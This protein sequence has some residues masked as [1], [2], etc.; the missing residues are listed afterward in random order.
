MS[1]RACA[2]VCLCEWVSVRKFMCA[3][4][5]VSVS[6]LVVYVS[7]LVYLLGIIMNIFCFSI[8]PYFFYFFTIIT[9]S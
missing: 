8:N 9:S 5:F 2:R 1:V 6:L 4:V 3:C 7:L